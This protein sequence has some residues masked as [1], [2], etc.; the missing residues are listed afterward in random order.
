MNLQDFEQIL[1]KNNYAHDYYN[2]IFELLSSETSQIETHE[3]QNLFEIIKKENF[4]EYSPLW[5]LKRDIETL[6]VLNLKAID[7]FHILNVELHCY[8]NY[9]DFLKNDLFSI[10]SS[11]IHLYFTKGSIIHSE[12]DEYDEREIKHTI[13]F[14]SPLEFYNLIK[15]EDLFNG[16]R[17]TLIL[18]H[19]LTL[20]KSYL[21]NQNPI[22]KEG[23][24]IMEKCFINPSYFENFVPFWAK[25]KKLLLNTNSLENDLDI[26]HNVYPEI[27][28]TYQ[29]YMGTPGINYE[30]DKS[31]LSKK[32]SE[33]YF[34]HFD[35]FVEQAGKIPNPLVW[36]YEARHFLETQNFINNINH[37]QF[38]YFKNFNQSSYFKSFVSEVLFSQRFKK[39]I[40]YPSVKNLLSKNF[41]FETLFDNFDVSQPTSSDL[42]NFENYVLDLGKSL[43]K[44]DLLPFYRSSRLESKLTIKNNKAKT[45]KI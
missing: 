29:N 32:V 22:V 44:E 31:M 23:L 20:E 45:H 1:I 10:L 16:F 21:H 11:E 2:V 43:K 26:L 36:I 24:D 30:L 13:S 19:L 34:T 12:Y 3:R 28:E 27:L 40:S 5:H 8:E 17:D 41:D 42:S 33:F 4:Y 9:F 35:S 15:K 6:F 14:H 25:Y 39:E 38:E 7:Q 18:E 37:Q